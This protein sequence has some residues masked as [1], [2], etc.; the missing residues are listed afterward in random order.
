[1]P[2][3]R[4][5]SF[6]PY[7]PFLSVR[8]GVEA[9][10]LYNGFLFNDRRRS[11]VIRVDEI[12]GLDDADFRDDRQENPDRHGETAFNAF[13]GGRTI[14]LKGNILSGNLSM[15]HKMGVDLLG[16]FWDLTEKDLGLLFLDYYEDFGTANVLTD[17]T[18]DTGAITLNTPLKNFTTTVA[19]SSIA[20]HNIRSYID[21]FVGLKYTT[22]AGV[23]SG[24]QY[25]VLKR[26]DSTNYIYCGVSNPSTLQINK[27]D[28]NVAT[29][30]ATVALPASLL[31]NTNYYVRA[32]IIDND[33]TVE[34][35]TTPPTDT[36]QPNI[37]LRHT[38]A[39]GNATKYGIGVQ[40]RA[41]FR[42][43]PP[44][45]AWSYTNFDLRSLNPGDPMV[46]C[47]KS[48]KMELVDNHD[49]IN[50]KSPFLITLRSSDHRVLSRAPV[51][52]NANPALAAVIFP[53][54]ALGIPFA[55]N[56]TILFATDIVSAVN[57]GTA[58]S[59][60][61]IRISGTI[62]NPGIGNANNNQ[63]IA[64]NTTI[65]SPD[66]YEIDIAKRTIVDSEGVSQYGK[67]A[68]TYD[69]VELVPGI[70]S[71]GIGGD[72][73]SGASVQLVFRHSW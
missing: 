16:A 13:Y 51:K 70:N 58:T 62:V 37:T 19:S 45:A 23:A 71:I 30:L 36:G 26:L 34:H 53:G 54:S 9:R 43:A 28:A 42:T 31:A 44:D 6:L 5:K 11:D 10:L 64:L 15:L 56:G 47:R 40:G 32:F 52:L 1:M 60:P 38:L 17:F 4:E 25:A 21:S 3:L 18:V 35:W 27:L 2:I 57:M 22:G 48:G 61:I 49:K 12:N 29:T 59:I 39:A 33:V 50:P 72:S 65:T 41:G 8:R 68:N 55:A 66:Y 46:T 73:Q 67:L 24:S 20:F 63:V 69:W 7:D 14:T